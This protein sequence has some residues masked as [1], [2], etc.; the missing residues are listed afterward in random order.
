[1]VLRG[2]LAS[3]RAI[4]FRR[5]CAAT[6]PGEIAGFRFGPLD[7]AAFA[8]ADL[9]AE[10]NRRARF[11]ARLAAGH[12]CFGFTDETGVPVAYLW[13]TRANAGGAVPVG[14]GVDLL[15]DA[16]D[17][18]VWD[19]RTAEAAQRRG[20][21]AN[22]LLRL[23]GLAAAEGADAIW[24]DCAPDNA[25]SI[26]GI[27]R[28]GFAPAARWRIRRLG[29]LRTFASD[30]GVRRLGTAPLEVPLVALKRPETGRS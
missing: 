7:A 20:L 28:A 16:G 24:I 5:D 23:A 25:A 17:A 19:C 14:P 6:G 15:P 8:A 4:L 21:Y 11:T 3:R 12:R 1:M 18:Y 29:P 13:L 10:R 27:V 2:H 30:N 9:F 26:A 22:A